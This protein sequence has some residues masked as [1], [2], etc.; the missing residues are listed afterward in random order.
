WN[1]MSTAGAS[2]LGVG[3]LLPALYLPISLFRGQRAGA[4]PRRATGLG[5]QGGGA[6]PPP[7][8]P[9]KATPRLPAGQEPPRGGQK[10]APGRPRGARTSPRH[11]PSSAG[12]TSTTWR[13]HKMSPEQP[14]LTA[15]EREALG[16]T[17]LASH[18]PDEQYADAEHQ[19][20]TSALGMW[21][22]LATEVLFFGSLFLG[23]FIY[24][25]A[26]PVEFE[27]ASR[28]LNIVIGG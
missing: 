14:L 3:Y 26:Y 13:R 23:L 10:R 20:E 27:A 22:F 8:L 17:I 9:H 11:Q 12:R 25:H 6:P 7:E 4:N 24:Q 21:N 19:Q 16:F 18:V 2:I 5:W 15:D 28:R 1:V